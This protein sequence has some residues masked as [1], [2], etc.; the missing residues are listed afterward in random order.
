M[1]GLGRVSRRLYSSELELSKRLGRFH[2]NLNEELHPEAP[3]THK[4]YRQ[5]LRKNI[6]TAKERRAVAMDEAK[7]KEG[8]SREDVKARDVIKPKDEAKAKQEGKPKAKDAKG[9]SDSH[10][11]KREADRAASVLASATGDPPSGGRR[12]R[13]LRPPKKTPTKET[14]VEVDSAS[15]RVTE[16]HVHYPMGERNVPQL[17]HRLDRAL[18]SPGIQWYQDPRTRIYNFPP[19]LKQIPRVETFDFGALDPFKPVSKDPRL[20]EA[21]AKSGAKFH[22][23]TSSMTGVLTQFY[24]LLNNY[25]PSHEPRFGFPALSKTS[26]ARPASIIVEWTGNGYAVE[27]DKSTG[28][29]SILSAMGHC[30]EA[31]LTTPAPEFEERYIQEPCEKKEKPA[32]APDSAYNYSVYSQF[33]MRSQLDCYDDRLPGNGTFDLKTRVAVP[34][35]LSPSRHDQ[36]SPYQIVKFQGDFESFEREYSDLI[37]SGAMLK[38]MFQARIGQMDGIYLAYHNLSRFFGFQY[39]PLSTLDSIFYSLSLPAGH[40]RLQAQWEA[41]N[42]AS[43]VAETQFKQS[44]KLW[45]TLMAAAAAEMEKGQ[46]YRMVLL[47]RPVRR[48]T[49]TTSEMRVV[50][51]PVTQNDITT[52]RK[53]PGRYKTSFREKLSKKDYFANLSKHED[54]LQRFN[55]GL[56]GR[57]P[58]TEFRLE[59]VSQTLNNYKVPGFKSAYPRSTDG[60]WTLQYRLSK[61]A[62][63]TA[64]GSYK[65]YKTNVATMMTKSFFWSPGFSI[66]KEI[67][68]Y[69]SVG[70][71]RVKAWEEGDSRDIEYSPRE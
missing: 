64:K 1:R 18:F 58:V 68:V 62:P 63:P 67:A 45:E 27:S 57:A 71:D 20:A 16:P 19:A 48:G 23:S 70:H 29:T 55:A 69:E 34:Y 54:D 37:R 49:I 28:T 53:F 25:N 24:Y 5:E 46:S 17:H 35:R 44:I 47:T 22:S 9:S 13:P 4:G 51:V 33:M 14:L 40:S 15:I 32:T 7:A 52:L 38:Y 60:E 10:K 11:S 61:V 59:V 31:F 41:T 66:D 26:R 30:L 2:S 39:L 21:A 8:K 65:D 36:D 6:M 50:V 43:Y 3:K 42:I 12:R 56:V